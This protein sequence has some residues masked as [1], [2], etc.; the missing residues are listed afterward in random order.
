MTRRIVSNTSKQQY[1]KILSKA[2]FLVA[3]EYLYIWI[4]T[5][6]MYGTESSVVYCIVDLPL[7]TFQDLIQK[8]WVIMILQI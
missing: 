4:T 2:R 3:T 6:G 7:F 5:T 1:Y 8:R